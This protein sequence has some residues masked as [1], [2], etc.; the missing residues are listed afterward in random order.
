V[1]RRESV[2]EEDGKEGKSAGLGWEG[3]K[4]CRFRMG[5]RESVQVWDGNKAAFVCLKWKR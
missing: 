4:V 1:G 3:W 2:Q 5:R